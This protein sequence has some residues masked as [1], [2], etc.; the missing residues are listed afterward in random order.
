MHRHRIRPVGVDHQDVI[1]RLATFLRQ[2]H[3]RVTQTGRHVW[4]A[5]RQEGEVGRIARDPVHRRVDLVKRPV[6]PRLAVAGQ[7]PDTQPH[8]PDTLR[9]LPE[10]GTQDPR[11]RRV[12]VIVKLRFGPDAAEIGQLFRPVNGRAID[13]LAHPVRFHHPVGAKEAAVAEDIA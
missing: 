7:R 10:G 5:S 6:L 4:C 2:H 3:P 8:D 12:A 1:G 11:H 13:I 9:A